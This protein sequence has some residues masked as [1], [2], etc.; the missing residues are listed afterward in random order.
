MKR[1]KRL[2]DEKLYVELTN[3]IRIGNSAIKQA[4]EE[5]RSFG[6]PE[7]FWKGGRVYYVLEN[8]EITLIRPEIMKQKPS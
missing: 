3:I 1:V 5:N 6:I 4:K 2:N 7:T 8:G